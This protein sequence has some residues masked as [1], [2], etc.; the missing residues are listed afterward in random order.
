MPESKQNSRLLVVSLSI[1]IPGLVA[2]LYFMPK[3]D[4]EAGMLKSLPTLNAFINGLCATC[5]VLGRM[6]IARGF[7][8]THKQLM[9]TACALSLL[10]LVFYV[11][12]HATNESTPY[13]GEGMMRTIYFIV[14]ISHIFLAM[15]IVPLV[16]ITVLRAWKG[17]FE[18]HKKIA[19]ITY[20]IWLYVSVSGVL[21]YLMI[22]PYYQ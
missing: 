13:G 7:R 3:P 18:K 8:E 10:F 12:Y 17:N 22:S 21:V 2:L 1:V 6:A 9:I 14:L 4:V 20:P 16:L 15:V 19:R 5:L 11:L